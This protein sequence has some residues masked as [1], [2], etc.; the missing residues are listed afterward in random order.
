MIT[1]WIGYGRSHTER[2]KRES[3]MPN[4]LM[5]RVSGESEKTGGMSEKSSNRPQVEDDAGR[6]AGRTG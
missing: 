1:N 4:P 2:P 3:L 6:M 5:P